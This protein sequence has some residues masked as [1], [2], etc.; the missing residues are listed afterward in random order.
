MKLSRWG[1]TTTDQR[2]GWLAVQLEETNIQPLT[3]LLIWCYFQMPCRAWS[4]GNLDICLTAMKGSIL[5]SLISTSNASCHK[6]TSALVRDPWRMERDENGVSAPGVGVR[7]LIG[8]VDWPEQIHRVFPFAQKIKHFNSQTQWSRATGPMSS[9]QPSNPRGKQTAHQRLI[10]NDH[11]RR[12][13][14]LGLKKLSWLWVSLLTNS[15]SW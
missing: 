7:W 10:I 11:P 2:L 12:V 1:K 3:R 8:P 4:K 15:L 6:F 13:R 14:M 5:F 9:R